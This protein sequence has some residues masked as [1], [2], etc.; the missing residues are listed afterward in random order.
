MFWK[1]ISRFAQF[2][3]SVQGGQ[4][5]RER[6]RDV[7]ALVCEATPSAVRRRPWDVRGLTQRKWRCYHSIV[8]HRAIIGDHRM[9]PCDQ[10]PAQRWRVFRGG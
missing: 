3:G 1:R 2:G 6:W 4:H 7:R 5:F 9:N 10:Q 8:D